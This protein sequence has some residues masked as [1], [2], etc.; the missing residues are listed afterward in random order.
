MSGRLVVGDILV[1]PSGGPTHGAEALVTV[2]RAAKPPPSWIITQGYRPKRTTP[3]V[4]L[5]GLGSSKL[6][7]QGY[8]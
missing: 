3:P 2:Q 6:G 1:L 4:V 7:G 8:G 5:Q